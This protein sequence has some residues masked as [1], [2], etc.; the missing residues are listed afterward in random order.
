MAR[1]RRHAAVRNG[2]QA[3]APAST[4]VCRQVLGLFHRRQRRRRAGDVGCMSSASGLRY[5]HALASETETDPGVRDPGLEAPR[6]R[7][8]LEASRA[9]LTPAPSRGRFG[10]GWVFAE[11]PLRAQTLPARGGWDRAANVRTHVGTCRMAVAP[12]GAP[13]T[14]RACVRCRNAKKSP[15][16]AGEGVSGRAAGGDLQQSARRRVAKEKPPPNR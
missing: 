4:H 10:W 7:N 8:S 16:V 11:G 14:K 15:T 3:P 5:R 9:A 1:L 13:T 6:G 2:V 12:K